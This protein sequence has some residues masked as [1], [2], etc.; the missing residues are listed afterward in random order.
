MLQGLCIKY[1]EKLVV[2]GSLFGHKFLIFLIEIL[3][4]SLLI[5]KNPNIIMGM[6][7]QSIEICK[8]SN[9]FVYKLERNKQY[10]NCKL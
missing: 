3:D 4:N 2:P 9:Q 8:E 7:V 1:S 6:T 10:F 5:Y